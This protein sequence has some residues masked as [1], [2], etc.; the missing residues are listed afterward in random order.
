[1]KTDEASF[2]CF[3]LTTFVFTFNYFFIF[4]LRGSSIFAKT[5]GEYLWMTGHFPRIVKSINNT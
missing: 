4:N 1:M 3:F 5:N 2:F